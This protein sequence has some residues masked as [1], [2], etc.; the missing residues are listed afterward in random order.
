MSRPAAEHRVFAAGRG[1]DDA[2][3]GQ[4]AGVDIIRV[5]ALAP[6][7]GLFRFV[8][9]RER[10]LT[11]ARAVDADF[12]DPEA[13]PWILPEIEQDLPGIER[14]ADDSDEAF[15]ARQIGGG[16][17]GPLRARAEIVDV[18]P[19][20]GKEAVGAGAVVEI[21]VVVIRRIRLAFDEDDLVKAHGL[22]S[23][24]RRDRRTI[25]VR[26]AAA[27]AG[28]GPRRP[29]RHSGQDGDRERGVKDRSHEADAGCL[30]HRR[31]S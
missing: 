24:G 7:R 23:D 6:P 30:V 4:I 22:R 12:P 25:R 5:P 9:G 17:D 26:P 19:V 10:D 16:D 18:D 11:Q 14:Q 15:A 29:R 3:I 21:R 2:T 8:V 27:L 1:K 13:R 31:P 20:F 28:T